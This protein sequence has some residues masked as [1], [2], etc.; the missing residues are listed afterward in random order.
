MSALPHALSSGIGLSNVNERLR[1]LYGVEGR[2]ALVGSPGKGAV[3]RVEIPL[4][5]AAEEQNHRM[6]RH[7]AAHRRRG[8]R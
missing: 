4:A 2:F 5:L 6:T 7:G 3:A 8:R 1:V